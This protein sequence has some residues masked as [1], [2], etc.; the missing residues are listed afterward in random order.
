MI[1]PMAN[2]LVNHRQ[3]WRYAFLAPSQDG[4]SAQFIYAFRG[5]GLR[6]KVTRLGDH[7]LFFGLQ[8]L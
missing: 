2:S 8:I 4:F 3:A 5:V 7:D 6:T 1:G